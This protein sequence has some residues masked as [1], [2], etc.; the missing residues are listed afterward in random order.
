MT[1]VPM[2]QEDRTTFPMMHPE[3]G[4]GKKDCM[5][6]DARG[7]RVAEIEPEEAFWF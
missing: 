6:R 1:T 3:G 5:S 7:W 4:V 2:M